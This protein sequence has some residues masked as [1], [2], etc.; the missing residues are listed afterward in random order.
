L[1]RLK[2]NFSVSEDENESKL[3]GEEFVS[4]FRMKGFMPTRILDETL[5]LIG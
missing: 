5:E 1:K 2:L 3:N 4:F